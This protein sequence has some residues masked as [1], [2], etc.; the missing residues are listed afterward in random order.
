MHDDER[1]DEDEWE[2]FLRESDQRMD[3]YLATVEAYTQ[4]HPFPEEDEPVALRAWR[5]GLRRFLESRGFAGY[6]LH[7]PM[8]DLDAD[9]DAAKA[10][11]ESGAA[12]HEEWLED[13]ADDGAALEEDPGDPIQ[14]PV[15]RQTRDLTDEVLDWAHALPVSQKNSLLVQ[16][17]NH[18][19]Q[20]GANVAKGHGIGFEGD[21]IGGNIACVK[22]AL[23]HA[24]LALALL[25]EMKSAAFM[26]ADRYRHY[27][28]GTFEVRNALGLYVQELRDRFNL[29]ID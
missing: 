13:P 20:I 9:S 14:V 29:G 5:A 25:Q 12:F 1:W 17:C 8:P 28:E 27:Y 7:P 3:R 19:M 23:N 11:D 24:N 15:F 18:L 21:A 10:G 4:A 22:R 16:F 6:P 2:A 26:E